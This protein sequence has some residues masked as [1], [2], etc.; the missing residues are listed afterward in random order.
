M[1][2]EFQ[3]LE[4]VGHE[5][6]EARI[7]A[8]VHGEV[9]AMEA[10][11]LEKLCAV[12]PDLERLRQA[13]TELHGLLGEATREEPAWT[14]SPERRA[15]LDAAFSGSLV[16]VNSRT[17]KT[18]GRWVRPVL[19]AAAACIALA[20]GFH[21][22]VGPVGDNRPVVK[23]DRHLPVVATA[24]RAS[25]AP[26]DF[27]KDAVAAQGGETMFDNLVAPAAPAAFSSLETSSDAP[28][29]TAALDKQ[30]AQSF[31]IP[32]PEAASVKDSLE[33]AALASRVTAIAPAE[34]AAMAAP[35]RMGDFPEAKNKAE[36][37]ERE[38]QVADVERALSASPLFQRGEW[39]FGSGLGSGGPGVT[40]VFSR[41][42]KEAQGET[43]RVTLSNA[44][45]A[46]R[47]D[48]GRGV[49]VKLLAEDEK[50]VECSQKLVSVDGKTLTVEALLR[51]AVANG[52]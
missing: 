18:N 9:S 44:K 46:R 40:W 31:V 29:F 36:L 47:Y 22:I 25:K 1:K 43:F 3:P 51:Q 48:L 34:T 10:A 6:T 39:R 17:A 28:L 38:A 14:L 35:L 27:R 8:W 30:P 15:R 26:A 4:P 19:L 2:D 24:Q 42:K 7:V 16:G 45:D 50:G 33:E 5:A 20:A 13:M 21:F 32:V 12:R 41:R 37:S 11:E 23:E 52:H 49:V